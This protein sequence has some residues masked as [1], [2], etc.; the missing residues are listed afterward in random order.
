MAA[1]TWAAVVAI[2]LGAVAAIGGV[3]EWRERKR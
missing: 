1:Y 2:V 3:L